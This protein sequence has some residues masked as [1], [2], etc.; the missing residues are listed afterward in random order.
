MT[1][2]KLYK[3]GDKFRV[4]DT[5]EVYTFE[6]I[7][8]SASEIWFTCGD[9]EFYMEDMTLLEPLPK[10]QEELSTTFVYP[11]LSYWFTDG[12]H[13]LATKNGNTREEAEFIEYAGDFPIGGNR[14][15]EVAISKKE[16]PFEV[17]ATKKGMD[18][19]LYIYFDSVHKAFEEL[20]EQ[21]A[22][23]LDERHNDLDNLFKLDY[24]PLL[25]ATQKLASKIQPSTKKE[26]T[27]EDDASWTWEPQFDVAEMLLAKEE[28]RGKISNL[29]QS[30]LEEPYN[31]KRLKESHQAVAY[32]AQTL[33]STLDQIKEDKTDMKEESDYPNEV[34]EDCPNEQAALNWG[35]NEEEPV[36]KT[37]ESL[38]KSI[39][40]DVSELPESFSG[41]LVIRM[42]DGMMGICYYKNG[43]FN[44]SCVLNDD[45]RSF[46]R[47]TAVKE[48]VESYQLLTDF[49]TE[50]QT[51]QRTSRTKHKRHSGNEIENGG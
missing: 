27:I 9:M 49:I 45:H 12:R 8:L 5:G 29:F 46:D 22:K 24:L 23:P 26:T 20:K 33:V 14:K 3:K 28:L 19:A 37:E 11:I 13:F 42:K 44:I 16:T 51:N 47:I 21:Y 17:K 36:K 34:E 32:A 43:Y 6:R 30:G 4:I 2:K 18:H 10:E 35:I 25:T 38:P 1:S 31:E 7:N 39:W 48:N 50:T 40:K 41:Q 15:E